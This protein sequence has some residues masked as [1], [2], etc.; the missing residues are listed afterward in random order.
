MIASRLQADSR[1]GRV[2]HV[3][4]SLLRLILAAAMALVLSACGGGGGGDAGNDAGVSVQ[5][6]SPSRIDAEILEG[7]SMPNVTLTGHAT[8]NIA[9]LNGQTVYVVIEDPAGLFE[10]Q[11]QVLLGGNGSVSV[12]LAGKLQSSARTVNGSLRI[13]VC[14]DMNCT[15]QLG[16]SPLSLPYQVTVRPGLSVSTQSIMVDSVFG[17]APAPRQ[18]TV[19]LP[20]YLTGWQVQ[21]FDPL[22]AYA[23]A[24]L[25]ESHDAGA[26]AEQSTALTLTLPPQAPGTYE[27][28]VRVRATTSSPT[29]P[30]LDSVMDIQVT[31][32][33]GGQPGHRWLLLPRQPGADPHPG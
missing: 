6:D 18:I 31:P 23:S 8:G 10:S 11:A 15:R 32:S 28:T 13:F 26:G 3:P 12:P 25:S 14:L 17:E 7:T 21:T 30:Y 19:N 1:I 27:A 22:H 5:L 24:Y 16:N 9:S 29:N 4:A 33:C 20:K 2:Q